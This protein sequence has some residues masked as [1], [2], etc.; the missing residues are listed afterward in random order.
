ARDNGS[1]GLSTLR[2]RHVKGTGSD[3]RFSF[4]GKSGKEHS[5][6]I[7]DRRLARLVKHVQELPGQELFQYL[8]DEGLQRDVTSADV[9]EYLQEV[10]GEP[11][12]AKDFRTWAGTVLA[13]LALSELASF[14]SQ[15]AAKRNLTRAIEQVANQL[16]NTPAVCRKSYIH[17]EVLDAYLDGSLLQFLKGQVE[18]ALRDRI[19]GHS[20]EEAAVLAFLQQ[21]LTREVARRKA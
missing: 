11:F 1:F 13:S 3:L 18:E 5:V 21:R 19:G 17:P 12:T 20:P 16:G 6:P 7:R 9:N 15:A 4:K 8:D 14:D 2:D 10:S